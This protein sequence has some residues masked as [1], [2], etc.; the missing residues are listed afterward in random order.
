[1]KTFVLMTL[2][3]LLTA[4]AVATLATRDAL[5]PQAAEATPMQGSPADPLV[6]LALGDSDAAMRFE[7]QHT[8]LDAPALLT[9]DGEG[10]VWT[11]VVTLKEGKNVLVDASFPVGEYDITLQN[12]VTAASTN[13]ELGDCDGT[14]V[15]KMTTKFRTTEFAIGTG[16]PECVTPEG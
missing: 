2:A 4:P 6:H 11:G 16:Q 7:V 5:D 15:A 9:I 14:L 13:I 8:G 3:S 1:M 12:L 10:V